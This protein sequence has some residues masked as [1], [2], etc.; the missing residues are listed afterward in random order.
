VRIET[1]DGGIECRA[2]DG[3]FTLDLGAGDGTDDTD[4]TLPEVAGGGKKDMREVGTRRILKPEEEE[5]SLV[6]AVAA[7]PC[8]ADISTRG[9]AFTF[10]S[11]MRSRALG[12][13]SRGM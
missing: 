9:V 10:I 1:R 11:R 6:S 3:D 8:N 4:G 13:L 7:G 2:C 5:G 12:D